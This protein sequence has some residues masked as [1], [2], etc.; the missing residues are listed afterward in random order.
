MVISIVSIVVTS[1]FSLTTIIITCKNANKQINESKYALEQQKEQYEQ[2]KLHNNEVALIQ[3]RPYLVIDKK[4]SCMSHGNDHYLTIVLKNKGNGSAFNVE[5][6][7][8][9]TASDGTV[10]S[11]EEPIQDPIVMVNELCETKWR[12]DSI[13][14]NLQFTLNIK[15]EDMSAQIYHQT[16]ILIIDSRLY[17]TVRNCGEPQLVSN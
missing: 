11:R 13:M 1:G 5:P 3:K 17:V 8:Q 14:P 2:E 16:I 9:I 4:T 10:I 6:E 12:F 7:T 15:F